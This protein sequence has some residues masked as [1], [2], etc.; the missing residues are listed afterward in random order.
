[1]TTHSTFRTFSQE[2]E[3]AIGELDSPVKVRLEGGPCLPSERRRV[4][5]LESNGAIVD[6]TIAAAKL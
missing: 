2:R 5:A 6:E 1:V 4:G 3:K